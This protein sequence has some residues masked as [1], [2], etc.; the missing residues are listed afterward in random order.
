MRHTELVSDLWMMP[1]LKTAE[2]E[3]VNDTQRIDSAS[4]SINSVTATGAC[5]PGTETVGIAATAKIVK[6]DASTV[7]FTVTPAWQGQA[8]WSPGVDVVGANAGAG[9]AG[10]CIVRACL[11]ALLLGRQAVSAGVSSVVSD[12]FIIEEG[13]A[14]AVSVQYPTDD[15][16]HPNTVR[17][18]I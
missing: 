3:P 12:A 11:Q 13:H 8:A 15:H 1:I 10:S 2:P 7:T 16:T 6:P 17:G 9:R 5:M 4:V 18:V 14:R